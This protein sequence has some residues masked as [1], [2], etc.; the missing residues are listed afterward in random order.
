MYTHTKPLQKTSTFPLFALPAE[1]RV[2]IYTAAL[3]APSDLLARPHTRLLS[4]DPHLTTGALLS[5]CKQVHFEAH[6]ILYTQNTFCVGS[7][8]EDAKEGVRWLHRIGK[9]NAGLLRTVV[10]E[11][12][13]TGL[14][15]D[16]FPY[17]TFLAALRKSSTGL[18][19][20]S[21][22]TGRG[23]Y[24][25]W[26]S[27]WLVAGELARFYR[28]EKMVIGD[29][30][31]GRWSDRFGRLRDKYGVKIEVVSIES[32][33]WKER[34]RRV[35]RW[36][37]RFQRERLEE[38]IGEWEVG[39]QRELREWECVRAWR[40]VC[41]C[42]ECVERRKNS[43]TDSS[44]GK[45][46]EVAMS[47]CRCD[48][49]EWVHKHGTPEQRVLSCFDVHEWA[50]NGGV[51]GALRFQSVGRQLG[52]ASQSEGSMARRARTCWPDRKQQESPNRPPLPPLPTSER[53]GQPSAS[54]E[55]VGGTDLYPD[56]AF[57]LSAYGTGGYTPKKR[58]R[59]Q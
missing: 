28:L 1:L 26:A 19:E 34:A 23:S 20:L 44:A 25:P 29:G 42:G 35:E 31:A 43:A 41:P 46:M 52:N 11:M 14:L 39:M 9:A 55:T 40:D 33:V 2:A 47:E 4:Q 50:A 7:D 5:T 3:T 10:V 45:G 58:L 30:M 13:E 59:I 17:V 38:R 27:E 53:N 24:L 15:A 57:S 48:D 18:R 8:A 6:S 32:L 22:W 51:D 36:R 12:R 56:P 21:I 37:E 49:C 54:E 16:V